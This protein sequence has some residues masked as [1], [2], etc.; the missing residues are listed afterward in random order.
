LE[1]PAFSHVGMDENGLG[2]QLGPMVVTGVLARVSERGARYL[3]ALDLRS[4]PR[5][6][7]SKKVAAFGNTGLAEAWAR[8]LCPGA[9]SPDEIIERLSLMPE[10]ELRAPCPSGVAP[11]CWAAGGGFSAPDSL[12]AAVEADRAALLAEGVELAQAR[13]VILCSERLHRLKGG[14][15]SLF[16][17]DL[18]AMEQLLLAFR[19]QTPG[20]LEAVCG[21]VGGFN[22]YLANLGP[23]SGRLATIE[24]EGRPR[25]TYRFAGLGRVSFVRDADGT[26][27]LVAIA[28]LVGKYLREVL[29]GKVASFYLARDAALI[30][31]SG[32]RDPVTA[33]F[34]LATVEARRAAGVP[35]RCFLRP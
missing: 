31:P 21:K 26:D 17:I 3:R 20:D 11:Q 7:D 4:M 19:E 13:S 27:A 5:I 14:G 18:N 34:V 25:S 6:D 16:Q 10:R 35:E 2:P 22:R 12:V 1:G 23:L 8:A 24:E 28:S 32:Y 33:R 9:A 29:M 15:R 30:R